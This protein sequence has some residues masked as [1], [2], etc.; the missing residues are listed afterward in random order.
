MQSRCLCLSD[1]PLSLYVIRLLVCS[2]THTSF[3]L[4]PPPPFPTL[5][6]PAIPANPPSFSRAH[7][8]EPGTLVVGVARMVAGVAGS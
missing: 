3:S 7:E 1:L 5:T 8:A 6:T 4:S 2:P